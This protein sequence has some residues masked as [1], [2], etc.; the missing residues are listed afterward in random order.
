MELDNIKKLLDAY[1]EGMTSLEEEK[2]LRDYFTQQTV[3]DALVQ[4]KPIFLGMEVAKQEHSHK[5]LL[6]PDSKPKV[7][8]AWRYSVAAILVVGLGVGSFY[9][10]QSRYTQEEMEALAAFEQ[11]KNAMMLLSENLNRG[12][13]QLSYV[14]QFA[15]TKDR[16]FE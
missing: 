5:A 13:E 7:N 14:K 12:T 11:S 8:K 6:L 1:F 4:Y 16:I 15:I 9:L 3:A 2:I 10:S